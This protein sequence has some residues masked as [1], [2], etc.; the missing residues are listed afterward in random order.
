M[1]KF[2][3]FIN[4]ADKEAAE[5]YIDGEIVEDEATRDF[6]KDFFGERATAS[7]AF[8]E[9]LK[10]LGGKPLKIHC[11]SYGGSLFAGTAMYCALSQYKGQKTGYIGAV[12]ASAAT[13][14]MLACDKTYMSAASAYLP[15]LPMTYA[16]GNR[17]D[18]ERAIDELKSVEETMIDA[19]QRKTG[20]RREKIRSIL[21]ADKFMSSSEAIE[22]GFVDGLTE[23]EPKL[24]ASFVENILASRM[25]IYNSVYRQQEARK[26]PDEPED[27][28]PA[29]PSEAEI[30]ALEAR[31]RYAK[32]RARCR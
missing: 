28:P 31:L 26:T 21:E 29:E 11:N 14:P 32:M 3:N 5:L 12:C 4:S 25:A 20:L 6:I 19:Y 13:F 24:D 17:L 1:N 2:Y 30:R 22:Y 23:D 7:Y 15:H 9:E 27:I 8:A 16:A 10:A 18:L